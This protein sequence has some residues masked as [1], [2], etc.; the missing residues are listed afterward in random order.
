MQTVQH[1]NRNKKKNNA[2]TTSGLASNLVTKKIPQRCI[3]LSDTQIPISTVV[4][5][6][7]YSLLVLAQ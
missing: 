1:A 7:A 3:P 6:S 4:N 2:N 5:Y